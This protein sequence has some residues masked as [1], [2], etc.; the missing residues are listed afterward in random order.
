MRSF[1]LMR[2]TSATQMRALLWRQKYDSR[3]ADFNTA[4]S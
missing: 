4:D 1:F 3:V 2:K